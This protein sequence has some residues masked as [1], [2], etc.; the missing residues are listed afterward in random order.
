M[1]CCDGK[2]KY[3]SGVLAAKKARHASAATRKAIVAYR[4]GVCGFFHI[5][6]LRANVR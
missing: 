4:C 6:H 3:M 2:N 1:R 5:G